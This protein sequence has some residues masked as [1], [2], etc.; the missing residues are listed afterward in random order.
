MKR[1]A[2]TAAMK[3]EVLMKLGRWECYRCRKEFWLSEMQWDHVQALVDGGTHE[4]SNLRPVC[5]GCH[6]EKSAFEHI[7]NSKSKRLAKAR[8]AHEAVLKGEPRKP[9]SIKSRGFQGHRKFN[10]E[11]VWRKS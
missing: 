6:R 4:P 5:V 1:P 9:G 10:G 3:L 11:A 8:K 7:R 2:I